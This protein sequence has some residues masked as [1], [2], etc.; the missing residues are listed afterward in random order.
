MTD[1]YDPSRHSGDIEPLT[2][3]LLLD[4]GWYIQNASARNDDSEPELIHG[5]EGDLLDP[6]IYACRNGISA[7]IEVKEFTESYYTNARSQEEY[8]LRIDKMN[9]YQQL[10][11]ES[12]IPLWLFIFEIGE[13]VLYAA[14]IQSVELYDS[15][16]PD[17][18]RQRYGEAMTWIAKESLQ[19]VRV[20]RDQLP[21]SFSHGIIADTGV[22]INELL[23]GSDG[24]QSDADADAN[25]ESGTDNDTGSGSSARV[26]EH[27]AIESQSDIIA[28]DWS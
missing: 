14:N 15:I 18:V 4:A 6:D 16:N 12:S 8:G 17:A 7:W 25:A 2:E 21:A 1:P 3:Q 13:G 11:T 22:E 24:S 26:T 23:T 27:D 5:A 20:S 10:A 19:T 28:S 9:R